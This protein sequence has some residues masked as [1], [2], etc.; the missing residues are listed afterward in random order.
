MK[1]IDKLLGRNE[2]PNTFT[3]HEVKWTEEVE[4]TREYITD[5]FVWGGGK[6]KEVTYC[7]EESWDGDYYTVEEGNVE[8][9]LQIDQPPAYR[10]EIS[11]E[12][13]TYT[14]TMLHKTWVTEVTPGVEKTG[15]TKEVDD[16]GEL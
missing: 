6:E 15:K 2:E 1:L 11:R 14:T 5:R 16:T 12:T 10:E 7:P 9:V 13:E 3:L 8:F 4:K